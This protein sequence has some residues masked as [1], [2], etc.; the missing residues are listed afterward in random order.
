M[1]TET[2]LLFRQANWLWLALLL[3]CASFSEVEAT[4]L[5][6]GNITVKGDTTSTPNPLRYFFRMV[7]Y[8]NRHSAG[9]DQA[10]TISYGDGTQQTIPRGPVRQISPEID[11]EVFT[12]DHTFPGPG[13]YTIN[14]IGVS[15]NGR[16]LNLAAPSDVYNLYLATTININPFR[17]YNSSP[18]LNNPPIYFANVGRKYAYNPAA[19]DAE[20]DS[21]SFKL[22]P[23]R[24]KALNT[25]NIVP[26]PGFTLPNVLFGCRNA[27]DTGPSAFTLD[28]HTGQMEWDAPCRTG[29]YT[30]AFVVEEWRKSP[31]G[32]AVKIG[33]IMQDMQIMVQENTNRPPVL[34]PK[35]TCIVAGTTLHGVI[36][37]T[38]PDADLLFLSAMSGIMPP[39]QFTPRA[40]NATTTG[41]AAG[42]FTWTPSC[43]D[44]REQPYQV[45]FRAEDIKSNI[46]ERQSDMQPWNIRVVASP[47]QNL[48]VQASGR[49]VQLSWDRY[50]CPNAATF[51][52]YRRTASSGF[53]RD[54]C[55]AGVPANSG[56]VLVAEVA[57][58]ATSFLDT[59]GGAGLSLFK[60]H[61]YVLTAGFASPGNGQSIASAEAC[62]P[63]LILSS[64]AEVLD[65]LVQVYPNPA[66]GRLQVE[67]PGNIS[68]NSLRIYNVA[69][70]LVQEMQGNGR[71]SIRLELPQLAPGLHLLQVN[72]NKGLV[73]KRV[74]IE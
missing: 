24:T 59:N 41:V 9:E 61:C 45:L 11:Q 3:I 12:W 35:D 67:L 40:S 39:A 52:I 60:K 29:E 55:N 15:R 37:A 73:T 72:T 56:Y 31:G 8:T 70:M 69:G 50:T 4:H 30:V 26:V 19:Y 38:D 66:Q 14:W 34:S 27:T 28:P 6:A 43:A 7:L 10:I 22:V 54:A 63:P 16:N 20:G 47:P 44:V 65:Q 48:A 36:S 2:N 68:W 33:E 46:S 74:L 21:L 18:V 25:E 5:R 62:A 42:D 17:G 51:R 53:T 23:P 71:N 57:S 58:D 32:G 49:H 1:S 13:T 64:D